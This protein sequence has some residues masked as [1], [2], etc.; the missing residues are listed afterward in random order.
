MLMCLWSNKMDCDSKIT[1]C[2]AWY[3]PVR[4]VAKARVRQD[5]VARS[6]VVDRPRRPRDLDHTSGYSCRRLAQLSSL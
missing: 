3:V 5:V 2:K 1:M 4:G 6:P